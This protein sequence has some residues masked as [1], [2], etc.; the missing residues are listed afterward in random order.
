MGSDTSCRVVINLKN[1]RFTTTYRINYD[2]AYPAPHPYSIQ[3]VSFSAS[4][5]RFHRLLVRSSLLLAF[6]S[7]P[8][9]LS[10]PSSPARSFGT[11]SLRIQS[12]YSRCFR[13][14]RIKNLRD[15]EIHKTIS[16]RLRSFN[17]IGAAEQPWRLIDV[18]AAGFVKLYGCCK[19]C[20]WIM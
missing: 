14:E 13:P 15:H 20:V 12:S 6:E 18:T 19:I 7:D 11:G 5:D 2:T 17:R 10:F 8:T 4:S 16:N 9:R 3:T 1:V